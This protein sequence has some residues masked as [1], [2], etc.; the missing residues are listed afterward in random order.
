MRA[1]AKSKIQCTIEL[2]TTLCGINPTKHIL[3]ISCSPEPHAELCCFR[4]NFSVSKFVYCKLY[5]N[6]IHVIFQIIYGRCTML[7]T[8][9]SWPQCPVLQVRAGWEG[10]LLQQIAF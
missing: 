8:L 10:T 2:T 5:L 4:L 3:I 7:E 1:T 9:N 6:S